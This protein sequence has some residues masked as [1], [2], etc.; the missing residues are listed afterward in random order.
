MLI[1]ALWVL[2]WLGMA[3]L[4]IWLGLYV[5]LDA[6]AYD[7]RNGLFLAS[8]F[9]WGFIVLLTGIVGLALYWL[10]HYS[11]L[12]RFSEKTRY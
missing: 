2:F 1:T 12:R 8:P 5:L 10:V 11:T 3:A 4:N 9:L 6:K 7:V